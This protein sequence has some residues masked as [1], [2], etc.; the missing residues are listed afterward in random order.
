ML[1]RVLR[2]VRAR[3]GRTTMP[4]WFIQAFGAMLLVVIVA[5]EK[6]PLKALRIEAVL[7]PPSWRDVLHF[8]RRVSINVWASPDALDDPGNS[9]MYVFV[10]FAGAKLGG[11][12]WE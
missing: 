1:V 3:N 9:S 8:R 5:G 12:K 10:R 4:V 11:E 6:Y 7:K 2:N